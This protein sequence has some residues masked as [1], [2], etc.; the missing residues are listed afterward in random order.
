MLDVCVS[1]CGSCRVRDRFVHSLPRVQL[2]RVFRGTPLRRKSHVGLPQQ[3]VPVALLGH[4]YVG[5]GFGTNSRV[6]S[7]GSTEPCKRFAGN[8]LETFALFQRAKSLKRSSW[9]KAPQD[10]KANPHGGVP[11]GL[12]F[13]IKKRGPLEEFQPSPSRGSLDFLPGRQQPTACTSK[14]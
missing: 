7:V 6:S 13:S 1:F 8:L 9:S 11:F 2:A 5:R 14:R 3:L 4:P 10:Q 12:P